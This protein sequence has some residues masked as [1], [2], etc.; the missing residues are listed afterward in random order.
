MNIY[1][2]SQTENNDYDTYDS[3]VVCAPD[4]QTARAMNPNNG[5]PIESH[6]WPCNGKNYGAWAF[7]PE[8]VKVELIGETAEWMK[9]GVIVASFNAS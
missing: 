4:D 9:Q 7:S 6:D 2:I 1:K 3:A 5:K 8:G